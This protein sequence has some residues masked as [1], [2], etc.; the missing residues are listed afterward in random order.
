MKQN[1][2]KQNKQPPLPFP[3]FLW[4]RMEVKVIETDKNWRVQ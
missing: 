1:K 4:S 3:P 2:I